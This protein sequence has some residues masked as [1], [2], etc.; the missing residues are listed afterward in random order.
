GNSALKIYFLFLLLSSILLYVSYKIGLRYL[1]FPVGLSSPFILLPY[2]HYAARSEMFLET[3]WWGLFF[4]IFGISLVVEKKLFFSIVLL[5]IALLIREL[6]LV[7]LGL[8]LIF[9]AFKRRRLVPVV[10]IPII[11]FIL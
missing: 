5:S 4:F 6:F 7:P 3:E 11:S 2:L 9:F 1:G 10:L 8:L